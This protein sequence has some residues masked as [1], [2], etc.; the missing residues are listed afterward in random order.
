MKKLIILAILIVAVSVSAA[1]PAIPPMPAGNV[2]ITG[3]AITGVIYDNLIN[4]IGQPGQLGFGVGICPPAK[5]PAGFT[6]MDGYSNLAS[7]NYGNYQFR[8]GSVMVYIPKFYYRIHTFGAITAITQANPAQVTQAAHGYA[9]GDIIFIANVSGMTQVN[10]LFYTVTKVNDDAYTIGVNS[11][12]F[13]AYSSGGVAT[14][15]FGAG[16][17][18]N[19][20]IVTHTT[21]SIQVR[22]TETY[23]TEALANAAGYALHRAFWDGNKEQDGFFVDKFKASRVANGTGFTAGSVQRGKPLSS[24][25]TH[26]PFSGLTGGADFLYSS[27]DLAKRR[28][29]VNGAVNASS[30][31]HVKSVF[32]NAA[33][34]M[35]SLVH[36]QYAQTDTYAAWYNA[37]TNFPKGCNSNTLKDAEDTAVI[38]ASDGFANACT[39]GSGVAF[40]KTT[41]NGQANGVADLN[42]GMWEFSLGVTSITANLTVTGISAAN[43]AEITT[44]AAHGL[45]TGDFVQVLS[46]AAGTLADAIN[47]RIWA[48][49]TTADPTK[50]TIALNSSALAAWSSGGTVTKGTFYAAKKTTA[51]KSFTSTNTTATDHWGA[52]GVAAMMDSFVPPFKSGFVFEMR[53]GS[54]TNQV[55]SPALSGSGW[56]LTGAGMPQN[57]AATDAS[58]THLFGR[59]LYYQYMINEMSLLSSGSWGSGTTAGV[60]CA[61]W[62]YARAYSYYSIGFRLACYLD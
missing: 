42:G 30:I 59:D 57:A 23:A 40:N 47:G 56:V 5:L 7:P 38:Y 6:P 33:L 4:K 51:M 36:G 20:T 18:F 26:N 43:P 14:K 2:N 29:G 54:G 55:L 53:M 24:A 16:F 27:V 12:A 41:H 34:A 44:S 10:G 48:I 13:T 21:N 61:K 39:T 19:D 22:G 28:D 32:Q 15:G 17:E 46:V 35:L 1:P 31:F 9:N 37:T 60:W 45:T 3:G 8:E 25:S 58:G 52:T 11:S 50:F 62:T 49:T